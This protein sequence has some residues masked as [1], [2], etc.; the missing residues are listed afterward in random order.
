VKTRF[1]WIYGAAATGVSLPKEANRPE[2][3]RSEAGLADIYQ[4]FIESW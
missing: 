3:V 1:D 4:P 2:A